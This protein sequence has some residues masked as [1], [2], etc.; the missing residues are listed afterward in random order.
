[1]PQPEERY[2]VYGI[3]HHGPG[4][5]RRLR[6]ALEAYQP[7]LILLEAP[8][9]AQGVIADL[10]HPDLELPVALVLYQ[11]AKIERASFL[12]FAEFSPE[13]QAIS[14]AGQYDVSVQLID[15][16]ARHYLAKEPEPPPSLF[17]P[18]QEVKPED[19]LASRMRRDPLLLAAEMAG[20]QDSERWWDATLERGLGTEDTFDKLLELI[21]DL[22]T[23]YPSAVDDETH[24][25]EA[26]M[27]Q[28][29]RKALK[30]DVERIAVIVGAWHGPALHDL[31]AYKVGTDRAWLKSLPKVKIAAA[32][33]P[34][35]YPRLA[36]EKG[37]GA[38][39]NSPAYYELLFRTPEQATER[40]MVAAAQLLREEGFDA[41]PAQATDGV[42]LA[43]SLAALRELEVPGL[44]ELHE[45]A[46]GT[47]AAGQTERLDLIREKLS[48]GTRV[49][50]LPPSASTVPLMADLRAELKTTRLAKYWE[51]TGEQYLR[52]SKTKPRGGLDLR[53]SNQN[54][55]S[56]LLHRLNL[57]DINWGTTQEVGPHTLGSF[58]E[59]WLLEWEPDFNL[60]LLERAGYGN[61]IPAAATTYVGERAQRLKKLVDL[62]QLVLDALRAGL[63]DLVPGLLENLR[64]RAVATQD[65]VSL[66]V[67][68]PTLINTI[69]YG[70]SRKTDTTGL[71]L[72]IDE[73]LPRI[74]AGLPAAALS[75]DDEQAEELTTAVG[76]AHQALGQLENEELDALWLDALKRL[77]SNDQSHDLC[78]GLSWRLLYDRQAVAENIVEQALSKALSISR[79]PQEVAYWIAGFL[80]ASGQLLLYHQKLRSLLNGWVTSLEWSIFERVLPALRRS[81]SNFSPSERAELLHLIRAKP[82][83]SPSSKQ[84]LENPNTRT[85]DQESLLVSLRDWMGS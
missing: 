23:A 61:T 54:R 29:L 78:A 40:W 45:A 73:I 35:T 55:A 38:G 12:P 20:Y 85:E 44:S 47:L 34:W 59:I 52:A 80:R 7:Q 84:E 6:M 82:G 27:R 42:D 69:R 64:E 62:A 81:F 18:K 70:D 8:A 66:L 1:M 41:G 57:L 74:T 15:L 83:R 31:K 79:P 43:K 46:L 19:A 51:T 50:K 58:K 9:D 39:V 13:Y 75:I 56:Q 10:R 25:R 21:A 4:S 68:L 17:T 48:L 71:L 32:W 24:R 60:F 65:P 30:E 3:R 72:L 33:V 11:E 14:W 76:R 16:P 26:H 36:R 2:R 77:A 53:K 67:G 37:Y 49:G 28:S 5:A 22:R 63:P